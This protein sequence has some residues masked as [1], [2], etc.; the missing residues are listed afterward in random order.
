MRAEMEDAQLEE[1]VSVPVRYDLTLQTTR[2]LGDGGAMVRVV[3]VNG[4]VRI[5]RW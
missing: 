1:V 3:T 4:A 2:E 5:K